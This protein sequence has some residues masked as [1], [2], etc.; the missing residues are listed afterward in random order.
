MKMQI[1]LVLCFVAHAYAGASE[2]D[3]TNLV[4]Q[5]VNGSIVTKPFSWEFENSET[6]ESGKVSLHSAPVYLVDLVCGYWRWEQIPWSNYYEITFPVTIGKVF[7]SAYG[8]LETPQTGNTSIK[9]H[10]ESTNWKLDGYMKGQT[11]ARTHY[12]H[13]VSVKHQDEPSIRL[14][15]SPLRLDHVMNENIKKQFIRQFWQVDS[16][17]NHLLQEADG[18]EQ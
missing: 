4:N 17:L 14:E 5:L 13:R 9:F 7:F 18:V 3:F 11:G 12:H 15:N 10:Y 6:H 16:K 1:A 8:I 2:S